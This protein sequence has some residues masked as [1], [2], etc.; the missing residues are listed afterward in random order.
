MTINYNHKITFPTLFLVI[1]LSLTL[2]GCG[3]GGSSSNNIEYNSRPDFLSGSIIE[4]EYDGVSDDLLTAGLGKSGI[5][6]SNAPGYQNS[7]QPTAAELRRN[8][9]HQNYRSLQDI[10]NAGGYGRLYGPNVDVDGVA[11]NAEGLIAGTE[12]LVYGDDGS[13][14]QMV[15]LMVQVPAHFDVDNPCIVTAPSSGSRGVYGAIG[16]TG[17]WGLKRGCAVAY[18]DKGTG[19]G[20]HNLQNDTVKGIQ[21]ETLDGGNAAASFSADLSA[22]QLAAFITSTPFRFATKHAHSKQNVWSDWGTHVLWSIEFAFYIINQQ[23]GTPDDI[24]RIPVIFRRN[25]TMV[26][27]SSISNGGGASIMAAEQDSVGWIDG[28]VVGEPNLQPETNND[29]SIQQGNNVALDN[30]IHSQSLLDYTTLIALY[31]PCA[32]LAPSN[33][34]A[35]FNTDQ[36]GFGANRCAALKDRGLLTTDLVQEQSIEAQ[37]RINTSGINTEQNILQPSYTLFQ[38]PQA[39]SVT[40]TNQHGRYGVENNLCG[41]SYAATDNLGVPTQLDSTRNATLFANAGGLPPGAGVNLIYNN[42]TSGPVD[43]RFSTSPSTRLADQAMDGFICLRDQLQVK[44]VKDGIN[45]ARVNGNLRGKPTIIVTGR[46][47]AILPINHTS[48]PY[49]ALNQL[50]HKGRSNLRYYEIKNAQHLDSLNGS[51]EYGELMLPLHYYYLQAMDLM[52]EHLTKNRALPPSQV[53]RTVPRGNGAPPVEV[54]VHLPAIVA[55]PSSGD[56][57]TFSDKILRVPE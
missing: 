44:R 40:Y 39:I 17:E 9:I 38:I 18:T 51:P 36:F 24:G 7:S 30:T 3:G 27:A 26:I 4:I 56:L 19:I 41:F 11:T 8:S 37:V 12:Y 28:I 47:D 1:F 48:R 15:A 6:S 29:F 23:F 33:N 31:Q 46:N 34:D 53:V 16:S 13:G 42:S 32:S 45:E 21:G 54:D 5:E 50:K 14:K 55:S 43:H 25:N 49:Y 57:I 35:P 20:Y 22:T 52:Y 10:T 2:S